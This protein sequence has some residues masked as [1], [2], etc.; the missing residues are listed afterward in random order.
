MAKPG[1]VECGVC[2]EV[3]LEERG[4]CVECGHSFDF[5]PDD[6]EEDGD[7]G[8]ATVRCPICSYGEIWP[9]SY[10]VRQCESCGYTVRDGAPS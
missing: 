7:D 4:F 10:G 5:R 1:E 9:L 6:G 2:G 8:R 3:G